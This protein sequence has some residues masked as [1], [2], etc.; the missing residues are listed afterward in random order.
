MSADGKF[1]LIQDCTMNW[2]CL[3]KTLQLRRRLVAVALS[4]LHCRMPLVTCRYCL[5][6]VLCEMST[7]VLFHFH[8]VL[9]SRFSVLLSLYCLYANVA[10]G[11]QELDKTTYLLTYYV[12]SFHSVSLF[13]LSSVVEATDLHPASL[14]STRTLVPTWVIDGS[15][16]GIRSNM[17]PCAPII[18]V[19]IM[20]RHV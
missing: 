17:L 4:S 5:A 3:V 11:L 19:S 16:K 6:T 1:T 20:V 8:I 13:V 9:L 2:S 18:V 14:A 12:T 10:Y 7:V 15:R